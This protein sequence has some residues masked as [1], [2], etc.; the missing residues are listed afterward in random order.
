[1]RDGNVPDV[2]CC[3]LKAAPVLRQLNAYESLLALPK[4]CL[5]ASGSTSPSSCWPVHTNTGGL[6]ELQD[7]VVGTTPYWGGML[8]LCMQGATLQCLL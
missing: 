5:A 2:A 6:L 7:S 3:D 1:M 8:M 4:A